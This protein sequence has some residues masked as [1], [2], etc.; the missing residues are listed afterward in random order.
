MRAEAQIL[1]PPGS[2]LG[3]P[4]PDVLF[5][6]STELLV[7]FETLNPLSFVFPL[8]QISL[9]LVWELLSGRTLIKFTWVSGM[10]SCA[11]PAGGAY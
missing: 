5:P 10:P 1:L 11:S 7:P 2:L 4:Q 9:L 8:L 3:L 6:S